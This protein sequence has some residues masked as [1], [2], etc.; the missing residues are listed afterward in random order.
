MLGAEDIGIRKPLKEE[1]GGGMKDF[2]FEDHE[3]YLGVEREG[4]FFSSQERQI[5]V[6]HLLNNLRAYKGEQLG[7]VK[8]L[9]G[10]AIGR[11]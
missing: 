4:E 1:F 3:C 6:R 9:E 11:V 7:K 5:I 10:Q 8:F 2:T